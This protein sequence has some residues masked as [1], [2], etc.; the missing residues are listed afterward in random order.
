MHGLQKKQADGGL[1]M[2]VR[3]VISTPIQECNDAI[4]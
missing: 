3:Q 4:G 1:Q 2:L